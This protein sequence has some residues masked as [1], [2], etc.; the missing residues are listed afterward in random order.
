MCDI[1]ERSSCSPAFHPLE[2]QER[3][4]NV[5]EA[6]DRARELRR[7]V[8]DELDEKAKEME[9]TEQSSAAHGSAG[10]LS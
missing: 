8:R 6:F 7:R 5:I 3:Y 10:S 2:E 9:A 1:C 4:E